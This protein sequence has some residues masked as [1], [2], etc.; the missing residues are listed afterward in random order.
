M[1]SPENKLATR[2]TALAEAVSAAEGRG[3]AKVVANAS[4]VATRAGQRVA[5]S[6]DYTVVALAGSTGSGKSSLFNALT[7]TDLA[8]V[9]VRRPTTSRA[10]AVG[11]G[12]ELPNEL[13]DWL[14]VGK[15]HLVAS[16]DER[17]GNLV[18][19]D[20]PDHDSTEDAHRV[21]VDRMVEMVDAL[22]WVVDPQKYADSALHDGYLRP[23]ADHADVMMV[24]LNQVDRLPADQLKNCVNDLRGLLD[25]EGLRATP[26]MAASA[27]RGDG[28]Y[29]VRDALIATVARKR[30]MVHR[31][32]LD[33]KKAAKQ[34]S[35][36]LGPKVPAKMNGSLKEQ[37]AETMGE[38]AGV[39]LVVT[40]VRKAWQRRGTAA[41]GW[42]LISWVSKLRP[43]P[44]KQ[45]RIGAMAA[46]EHSPT[47]VNRTS[48]PKA[49]AVQ[50]ARVDQ[51]LRQLID[52]AAQG[53]PTGWVAAVDRAAHEGDAL[54]ADDLD[55]AIASTDLKVNAG[56]WWWVLFGLLQWLLILGVVAG[57][58]WWLAGPAL[59]ASGFGVPVVA[60]Y[61]IPAGIWVAVGSV[62]AGLLLALA[63][64]GLVIAGAKSRAWR[65]RKELTAAIA[66]VVEERVFV[67]VQREL[68]RYHQ[69]REAVRVALR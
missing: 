25:E 35:A 50:K 58:G 30:A 38:A 18:L 29:D 49:S 32:S 68:D 43:D 21:T 33:V 41:T 48:L 13:L 34:L 52:Q 54:L 47:E 66:A 6:G 64:R 4:R 65:A 57:V 60:W 12:T 19:L 16:D 51:G 39:D 8:Q 37:V 10:M 11:W 15:R 1:K 59:V 62:V 44:L 63:G 26:L 61:G 9:A 2:L 20:L 24:V 14:D 22:L 56:A 17:L 23:L 42:P 46:I 45:L 53:M 27:L 31:L 67:P 7:G 3:N 55:K 40:G 5:L 36:D 69:A 28:I